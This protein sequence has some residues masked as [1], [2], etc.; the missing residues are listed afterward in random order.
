MNR[1]TASLAG[2]LLTLFVLT[3]PGFARSTVRIP[4]ELAGTQQVM[5]LLRTVNVPRTEQ[6]ARQ[7]AV[8]ILEFKG[9][10]YNQKPLLRPGVTGLSANGNSPLS[11]ERQKRSLPRYRRFPQK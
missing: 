2:L 1:L 11:V 9:Q 7:G 10:L 3:G 4:A 6:K 8:D 5:R